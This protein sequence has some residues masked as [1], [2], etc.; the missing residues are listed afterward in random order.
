M[1]HLALALALVCTAAAAN[2]Q[3]AIPDIKGTWTGKDKSIVYGTNPHHP[4]APPAAST[5]RVRDF[6]FTFVVDGQDGRLAWGHSFSKVA[7]TNESFAWAISLD[8]K[9][10]VGA[11]T[12]GYYHLSVLSAD[13]METCY[14]HAGI[15]PTQS[16]VATCFIL[17]RMK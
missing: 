13:R 17:N 7:T 15:S 12:D 5:P 1:K 10:I 8:G 6:E 9:T 4:G 14:A 11:D 2:A 16:I 3:N